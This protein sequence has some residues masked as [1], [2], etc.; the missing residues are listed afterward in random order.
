MIEINID[1][2]ARGNPG[3]AGYGIVAVEAGGETLAEGYGFI[4]EQTNNVAEYCALLAALELSHKNGWRELLVRS[5]SQLLVRQIE[6]AY[7]VKNDGLRKLHSR[8]IQLIGRFKVFE[9]EHVPRSDNK[10]A[11][12]L[13]NKGI[14]EQKSKPRGINPILVKGR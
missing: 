8:A 3:P 7:K 4:G 10:L 1:G 5:D 12:K 13:A 14:D 9:I 11:D 2:A 6:G